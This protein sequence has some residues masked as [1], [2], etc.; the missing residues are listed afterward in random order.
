[1]HARRLVPA[2]LLA[3]GC[4][5]FLAGTSAAH[6]PRGLAIVL[7]SFI[8]VPHGEQGHGSVACPSGLVPLSGS[9]VTE[10]G[11]VLVNVNDS[12]PLPA[13]WA[14]D[15]NN[16][17]ASDASFGVSVVC[18]SRPT[19]YAVVQGPTVLVQPGS[20]LASRASCPQG[21]RPLGGGV[22]SSSSSLLVN[23]HSSTPGGTSWEVAMSNGSD[24]AADASAFAVCGR[25][26]GYAVVIGR[27]HD[28]PAGS[29]T[30]TS[31]RCPRGTVAIGGGASS[32]A[33]SVRVNLGTM[34]PNG[35]RSFQSAMDNASSSDA[36]SLTDGICAGS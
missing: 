1:M 25:L 24:T 34:G 7:S 19:G 36:R 23:M 31:A 15:V 3:A 2:L 10:T 12:F 33:T 13:G 9:V 14:A 8:V 20:Q 32:T 29:Q 27:G 26:A 22:G 35:R 28:N 11:S 17:S 21:S 30:L 16:A 5:A 18:A 6:P 4:A